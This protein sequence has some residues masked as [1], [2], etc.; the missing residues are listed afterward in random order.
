MSRPDPRE[1]PRNGHPGLASYRIGVDIGGTFTD[2]VVLD[3]AGVVTTWKEESTPDDPVRAIWAGLDG[4]ATELQLSSRQLLARTSLFVHGSTIATNAVIQR[5][6][7]TIGL[8]CTEGFRDV[9]YFRDGYKWQRFNMHLPRP[10][11]F[12]DRYLRIG[13]SERVNHAGEILTPLDEEEVVRAAA[14]LRE[15]GAEAVAIAFLWSIVNPTHEQRAREVL[16]SELPECEIVVSSEV[17]P[18]I[19]EWERTSAA[20]LSAY[21]L[22]RIGA[23]LEEFADGLAARGFG[24]EPLIMQINGGSSTV[25]E[26]VRRPV[27][28]LNSGPAAAPA[29]A[30]HYG[31]MIGAS[32]VI[33]VDMGGTSFDV[34]MIRGGRPEMS[35]NIQVEHQPIGV[36]GVDVHSIGAG[37]GSIAW[38]D[39]GRA[40]R[41]GP[42]SAGSRPGPACYALG[43]SEPTVTDANVVL[44]Y[45]TPRSFFGGRRELV[46]A[47]AQESIG[48][49]IAEPLGLTVTRAAAGIFEVVNSNMIGGIRT[50]SIERGIDPRGFVLISAGG[51]GGLH[52]ARLARQLSMRRVMIPRQA[53]TFCAFGMTVAT[54]RHDFVRSLHGISAE[55][56]CG[57]VA[58]VL[59]DLERQAIERLAADGFDAADIRLERFV[60]ARYPSQIHELTIPV[61]ASGAF[62]AAHLR[63]LEQ[64][65]HDEHEQRYRYSIRELPI[66]L[67][68]WRVVALGAL[69]LSAREPATPSTQPVR[70]AAPKDERLAY[71][72]ELGDMAITPVY[73]LDAFAPGAQVSGP[74]IIEAPDTT[75]AIGLGDVIRSSGAHALMIE[76]DASR[77]RQSV[78]EAREPMVGPQLR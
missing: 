33:T 17:L 31:A 39:S 68:H 24:H 76:I 71:A 1:L 41:V 32:D 72:P 19:R 14:R 16:R 55:L 6:G 67:L 73:D 37:G 5:S 46:P 59:G 75:I 61:Q 40:L 11:D 74:A 18:E 49:R 36:A 15:A 45:L 65:F 63:A 53:G 48:T 77:E 69:P 60:D 20:V 64:S 62:D 38:L 7:P 34:S 22:P 50:V 30:S 21:V 57:A 25:A 28:A 8:L 47:L 13:I 23:Y 35:R 52:A 51:A 27:Y 26:I 10:P 66:E 3:G 54:V 2:F 9:V 43:G 4:L 12:V 58:G 78:S 29:A 42:R 70:A 56:D 44:G